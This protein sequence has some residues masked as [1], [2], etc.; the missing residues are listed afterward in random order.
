MWSA[1]PRGS[2]ADLIDALPI[3][4]TYWSMKRA[5]IYVRVSTDQQTTER[6]ETSV[7]PSTPR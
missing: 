7:L 5:G 1:R 4:E 6:G 2:V 3:R